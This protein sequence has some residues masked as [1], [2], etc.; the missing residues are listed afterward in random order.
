MGPSA[1]PDIRATDAIDA[2]DKKEPSTPKVVKAKPA[3]DTKKKPEPIFKMPEI[4]L[5]HKTDKMVDFKIPEIN[6]NLNMDKFVLPLIK[7]KKK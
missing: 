5:N 6:L 1:N 2:A 3:K 4:T 7:K